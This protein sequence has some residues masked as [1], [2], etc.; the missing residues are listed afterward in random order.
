M[1][2]IYQYYLV[3]LHLKYFRSFFFFSCQIMMLPLQAKSD[4]LEIF[5]FVL[6]EF[7]V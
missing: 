6:V 2:Q 3:I 1:E 5:K 7:N 4:V